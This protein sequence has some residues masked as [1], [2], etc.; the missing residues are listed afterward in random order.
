M[1][2]HDTAFYLMGLGR[3]T[4]LGKLFCEPDWGD[5]QTELVI[6]IHDL[7]AAAFRDAITQARELDKGGDLVACWLEDLA[8]ES[9]GIDVHPY[10]TPEES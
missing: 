2:K 8:S 3:E 10:D 4:V 9:L 1:R 6:R 7:M 5:E